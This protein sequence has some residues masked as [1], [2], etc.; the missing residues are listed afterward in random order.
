MN[1]SNN[2]VSIISPQW[3]T[4]GTDINLLKIAEKLVK[5]G[6]DVRLLIVG[7]EWQGS[8]LPSEIKPIYLIPKFIFKLIKNKYIYWKITMTLSV[9]F[10]IVPLMMYLIRNQS[11]YIL[12]LVPILAILGLLFCNVQ[13]KVIFSIQGLPRSKIVF[14]I[15]LYFIKFLN[16]V[17]YVIPTESMKGYL[18]SIYKRSRS[19]EFQ[20]IP[21]A[22][23]DNDLITK[24]KESVNHKWYNNENFFVITAVGRLTNQK[25]FINLINAFE[26]I[27][28]SVNSIRLV[29]IGDGEQKYIL[30]SLVEN[31]NLD[32]K[33]EFLGFQANPYK[34]MKSSNLFVMSSKWEGPGHVLIEAL[35]LGCPVITTDC[36]IGP[37]DSIQNG[38]FGELVEVGNTKALSESIL[39]AYKNRSEM[40]V[41][42]KKSEKY[43]KRFYTNNVVNEY[44]K[45]L[46]NGYR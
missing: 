29:I 19:I 20:V 38:E 13:S 34:F 22:V 32:S 43:M 42:V 6:F 11:S 8:K 30:K 17:T 14:N 2:V 5:D 39:H 46:S 27:T 12:G 21:N 41:K 1:N 24:S 44:K 7:D 37:A 16:D 4:A 40:L 36:P 23:L 3:G 15:N 18:S 9:I 35:G 45:F 31:L 25:D 26:L 33:V 28:H 10:S